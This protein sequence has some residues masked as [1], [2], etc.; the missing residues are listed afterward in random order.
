MN[1]KA[2]IFDYGG[3]IS[4]FQDEGAIKDMADLAGVDVSLMG[5]IY[6]DNR[7]IYDQGLVSGKEYFKNIL[8]DVGVFADD[9]LLQKLLDRDLQSWSRVN[10]QTEALIR[11]L[12]AAGCKVAVL[13]NMVQDFLD[14][15]RDKL[16]VFS[17]LDAAVYSCEVDAVKPEERI[18][19]LI[20]EKLG[21]E[22][23][24]TAFFDDLETNVKAA[25]ALGIQAFFWK[26]PETARTELT[27]L[28]LSFPKQEEPWHS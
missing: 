20:L 28:G 6:W 27:K 15:A 24:E 14:R 4:F 19:R 1:I 25:A 10:P 7:P 13:S 5:R 26:D 11:E 21:C 18:Y 3:V 16:P 9:G 23:E 8:A 12:K 17:S 22:A 2:V